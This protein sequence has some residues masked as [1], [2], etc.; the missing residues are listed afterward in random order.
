MSVILA[1]GAGS[2]NDY[3][4]GY[5]DDAYKILLHASGVDRR[6][7]IKRTI[8]LLLTLGVVYN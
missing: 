5:S 2:R 4:K 8:V 6:L 3:S 7:H 1:E